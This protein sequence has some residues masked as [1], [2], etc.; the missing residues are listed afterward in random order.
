[1]SVN[2]IKSHWNERWIKVPTKADTRA[3]NYYF[4]DYGRMKSVHKVTEAENQLT[5]GRDKYGNT[6][7]SIRLIENRRQEYYLHRLVGDEFIEPETL[8]HKF[9]IRVD[10]DKENNHFKNLQWMTQ[11]EMTAHQT[12]FGVFD[13]NNKKPSPN[14]KMTETKVRLLKKRLAKG[15]TKR[16]IL[17]KDF[18]ITETQVRRIERGENWG[19]VTI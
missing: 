4:S 8:G 17:A 16:K 2:K 11:D 19:H 3:V 1:M 14:Q 15:K 7:L 6:K 5:G 18:N 10:N 9:L 12:K 13:I